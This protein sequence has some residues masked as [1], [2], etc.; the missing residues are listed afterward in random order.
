MECIDLLDSDDDEP[1]TAP[2]VAATSGIGSTAD[3]AIE[4]SDTEPEPTPAPHGARSSAAV[5]VKRP[6]DDGSDERG[7]SSGGSSGGG[8]LRVLTWNPGSVCPQKTNKSKLRKLEVLLEHDDIIFLPEAGLSSVAA[9]R[10]K[11]LD[12][13]QSHG[14]SLGYTLHTPPEDMSK[15]AVYVGAR[16]NAHTS[17][18]FPADPAL[19]SSVAVVEGATWAAVGVYAP[20]MHVKR[21][22]SSKGAD[23]AG[24]E[25]FDVALFA[26]L[27]ALQARVATVALLGDLNFVWQATGGGKHG[28]L[29]ER[30]KA[31]VGRL[32][33]AEPLDR[34]DADGKVVPTSRHYPRDD[35]AAPPDARVDFMFVASSARMDAVAR[36]GRHDRFWQ[37]LAWPAKDADGMEMEKISEHT[38]LWLQLRVA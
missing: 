27:E 26:L 23:A 8:T 22:S 4:L 20:N 17:V 29:R 2:P 18:S 10:K 32:G 7:S 14:G 36:F 25:A 35:R 31:A 1:D 21:T 37:E 6:R 11:Q 30:W 15:M 34:P 12:E 38:P 3:D 5:G 16:M 33:F 13:L 9:P 24:R 28:E 19:R